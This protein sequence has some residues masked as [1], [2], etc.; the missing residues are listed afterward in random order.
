V[1]G[2]IVERRYFDVWN[3]RVKITLSLFGLQGVERSENKTS[4]LVTTIII[5]L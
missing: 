1:K 5:P 3:G 4:S 2:R